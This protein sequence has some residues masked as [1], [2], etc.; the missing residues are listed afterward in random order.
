MSGGAC[1]S[2][3]TPEQGVGREEMWTP[4]DVLEMR[5]L[6]RLGTG[7]ASD[8]GPAGLLPDDSS[9]MAATGAVAEA[10]EASETSS[11]RG[12]GGVAS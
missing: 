3:L 11:A 10:G 12:L 4:E 6:H 1:T 9:G 7:D 2:V 5:R 8:R